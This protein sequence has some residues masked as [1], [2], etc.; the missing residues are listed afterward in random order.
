[1]NRELFDLYVQTQL[2]PTLHKGDVV[3]LNNLAKHRSPNVAAIL[4]DIGAWFRFRAKPSTGRRCC[5][6]NLPPYSPDLNPI[7]MAFAKIKTVRR[8]N[9]PPGRFLNRLTQKGSSQK[10]RP[11]LASCRKRLQHLQRR[12]MLQLLQ[13]CG[14]GLSPLIRQHMM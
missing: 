7:E 14:K 10:L 3:I 8:E 2:A 1:M 4:T 6:S 12:R 13:G 11:T 9:D 5:P